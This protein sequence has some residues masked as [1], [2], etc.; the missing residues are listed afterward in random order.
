MLDL[1]GA[2]EEGARAVEVL[3]LAEEEGELSVDDVPGV[4]FVV[5]EVL[6]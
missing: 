5:V 6:G 2:E 4:V 3:S 1:A